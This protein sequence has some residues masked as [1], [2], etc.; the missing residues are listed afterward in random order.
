MMMD[1]WG[2]RP[3]DVEITLLVRN[4]RVHSDAWLT[5]IPEKKGWIFAIYSLEE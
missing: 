2:E 5:S 1:G 3:V 4:S